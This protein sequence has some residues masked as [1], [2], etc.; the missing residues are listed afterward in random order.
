VRAPDLYG[1]GLPATLQQAFSA[2]FGS[3]FHEMA[4]K[5]DASDFDFHV[6]VYPGFLKQIDVNLFA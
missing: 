3:F 6:F 4:D 1:S 2:R 5:C